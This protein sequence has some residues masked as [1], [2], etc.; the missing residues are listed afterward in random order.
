MLPEVVEAM[1]PWLGDKWGNP[2]SVYA[3]G[4]QARRAVE[5]AREKVASLLVTSPQQ[6]VFTSGATEANNAAIYSALW[7]QPDK[8]HVVTSQVEHSAVLAYC[9]HLEKH[10]E[11]EVTKLKCWRSLLQVPLR[12]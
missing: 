1:L 2:S 3:A 9:E 7:S 6:V 10:W 4:R 12:G 5:E 11:I 8:R